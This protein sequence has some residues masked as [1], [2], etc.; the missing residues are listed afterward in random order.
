MILRQIFHNPLEE[1]DTAMTAVPSIDL[2]RFLREELTRASP[3]L[4]RDL[5]TTFVNA[6]LSAQ[7]D[8]V[9]G[10]GYGARDPERANRR[11][12]YRH[13]ELD[14]RV[15]T[16]YV[17]IPKLFSYMSDPSKGIRVV[18]VPASRL[19]PR[20]PKRLPNPWALLSLSARL[21]NRTNIDCDSVEL[22][23]VPTPCLEE[24]LAVQRTR[25]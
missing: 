21:L 8:S 6:I 12:A 2:A 14:T 20:G 16:L 19:R 15:G 24:L 22:A 18:G 17:A 5:L 3:N 25:G 9:C 4:M 1:R 23:G 11:N 13:R 7:A 10:T